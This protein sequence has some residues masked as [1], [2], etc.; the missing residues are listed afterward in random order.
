MRTGG[1]NRKKKVTR[2]A[3]TRT[4]T[5]YT[6]SSSDTKSKNRADKKNSKSRKKAAASKKISASQARKMSRNANKVMGKMAKSVGSRHRENPASVMAAERA[7]MAV[8]MEKKAAK[9]AAKRGGTRP[10]KTPSKMKSARWAR[11]L[12]KAGLSTGKS[13]SGMTRPSGQRD[14]SGKKTLR[15]LKRAGL[16]RGKSTRKK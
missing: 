10:A 11:K 8:K 6:Y 2:S 4:M 3:N 13:G 1:D 9:K 15:T 16:S 12:Q 14:R 7:E 5:K